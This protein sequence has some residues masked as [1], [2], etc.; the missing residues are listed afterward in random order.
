MGLVSGKKALILGVANERSIAWGIAKALKAE[1]AE[2]GFTFVGD[3]LEKR[4]RPLAESVDS[5]LIVEC[6]VTDDAQIDALFETV[7]EKWGG[8]DI[9]VHSLAFANKDE[10]KGEYLGTSREGFRLAMDVSAYSLV[11]VCQRATPLMEERGGSIVTMTY[12]GS[13]QVIENYN[14]MGVAKAALEASV[15]YLASDLGPK[16]IRINA[17][18]AG[19]IKTL[20]AMGISGF[21][22]ILDRVEERAPLRRNVT[23]KDVG[24][25]ALYL[26]SDL[27]SGVTGELLY[28]DSGFNIMGL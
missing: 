5:D 27:A 25:T 19:P 10:L 23:P 21:R 22:S 1:G 17:I 13:Q 15:K 18:S 3:K 2:L 24:G 8:L 11:A 4:V 14:V 16:G 9:L 20:A 28:V 12:L 26:L 6:D 7:K